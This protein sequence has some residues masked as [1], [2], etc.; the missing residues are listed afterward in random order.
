VQAVES[1]DSSRPA[2][3]GG[4]DCRAWS[5]AGNRQVRS[6]F[7][8]VCSHES[9]VGHA[10]HSRCRVSI[11]CDLD[12][13]DFSQPRLIKVNARKSPL[14]PLLT[15]AL[16]GL[17]VLYVLSMGPLIWLNSRDLIDPALERP[18]V[19]YIA[20]FQWGYVFGP[21]WVASMLEA[22]ADLWQ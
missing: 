2:V 3:A 21:D 1:P 13:A 10:L 11:G 20:P 22:Y 16:I 12:D 5:N 6:A 9:N 15:A 4:V 14:W 19:I 18:F 17:P 8:Q 7:C